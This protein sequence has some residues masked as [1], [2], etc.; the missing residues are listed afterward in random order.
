MVVARSG[1]VMRVL[2]RRRRWVLWNVGERCRAARRCGVRLPL[3]RL[4]CVS[5]GSA[6]VCLLAMPRY[7][8]LREGLAVGAEAG[9]LRFILFFV[10]ASRPVQHLAGGKRDATTRRGKERALQNKDA[11]AKVAQTRKSTHYTFSFPLF[12]FTQP[13]AIS[14]CPE[15]RAVCRSSRLSEQTDRI[16]I[17]LSPLHLSSQPLSSRLPSLLLVESRQ[18]LAMAN[19]TTTAARTASR[20][21][22]EVIKTKGEGGRGRL[23]F[24]GAGVGRRY[25]RLQLLFLLVRLL[26][27]SRSQF[28]SSAFLLRA[29]LLVTGRLFCAAELF[30]APPPGETMVSI[31]TSCAAP[32]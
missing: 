28:I 15:D 26:S 22:D 25:A 18:D 8:K 3:A 1:F 13:R 14:F 11:A 6:L 10:E 17:P 32:N 5:R 9:L 20:W 29:H 4:P 31:P 27:V 23:L 24:R 2:D 12:F 16:C 19:K 30:L 21:G 7:L